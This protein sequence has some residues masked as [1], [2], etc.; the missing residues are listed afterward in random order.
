MSDFTLVNLA[1]IVTFLGGLIAGLTYLNKTLKKWLTTVFKE[2]FGQIDKRFGEIENR[3]D[4]SDKEATK[5]YLVQFIST[6]KRGEI[7]SET[8]KQRFYE[9]YEHYTED[10]DGNSYIKSEV[11]A[12]KSKGYI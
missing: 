7:I 11:E 1:E 8:E 9:Q 4:K 3:L 12:L 5:N 2:Q 10:L 6:V